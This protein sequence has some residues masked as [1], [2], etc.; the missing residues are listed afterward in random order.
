MLEV[1]QFAR[2]AAVAEAWLIVQEPY[3]LSQELGVRYLKINL[4]KKCII[5]NYLF[6]FIALNWWCREPHQET[7]GLWEISC[8]S[9]RKIWSAWKAHHGKKC[10]FCINYQFILKY[11]G[12][13]SI[14]MN[15]GGKLWKFSERL[16]WLRC[17][18]LELREQ[19]RKLGLTPEEQAALYGEG[20]SPSDDPVMLPLIMSRALTARLN[21]QVWPGFSPTHQ[22]CQ[23]Y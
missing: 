22:I 13:H 7:W 9:G 23:T 4:V 14:D 2:D 3:L 21:P 16:G 8:C 15:V 20:Y 18:Q 19:A 12:F 1:Y 11:F 6:I 17:A 5:Y 10:F